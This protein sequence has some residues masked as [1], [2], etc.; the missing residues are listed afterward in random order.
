MRWNI[1]LP[2]TEWLTALLSTIVNPLKPWYWLWPVIL[3][4]KLIIR[5]FSDLCNYQADSII[6]STVFKLSHRHTHTSTQTLSWK[7]YCITHMSPVVIKITRY[8]KEQWSP[9]KRYSRKYIKS[10]P[11]DEES[12]NNINHERTVSEDKRLWQSAAS[13]K[14]QMK[15]RH[16]TNRADLQTN[17]AMHTVVV[18]PAETQISRRRRA[19]QTLQWPMN[20]N[21]RQSCHGNSTRSAICQK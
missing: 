14:P 5:F 17:R 18:S 3:T 15:C 16:A 10:A 7:Q 11:I 4:C 20:T 1:S 8:T 13:T 9:V 2:A 21:T 19:W 12:R 6:S